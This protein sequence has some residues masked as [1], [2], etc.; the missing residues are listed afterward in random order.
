MELKD[1]TD[2]F[3][4]TFDRRIFRVDHPCIST[5]DHCLIIGREYWLKR[6]SLPV[7]KI[8]IK[9]VHLNITNLKIKVISLQDKKSY[10]I[11]QTFDELFWNNSDW[12]IM[13]ISRLRI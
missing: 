7:E 4:A 12:R 3:F 8:L 2:S 9:R 6:N 10:W 11:S 5:A 1:I 13:D